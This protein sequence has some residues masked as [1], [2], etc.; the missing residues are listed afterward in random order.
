MSD[1]V[2]RGDSIAAALEREHQLVD[3]GIEA[4][5][6]DPSS[7]Q[8]SDRLAAAITALRRH[9]YLEEEFLFPAVYAADPAG[10]RASLAVMLREHGQMWRVLDEVEQIV[11]DDGDTPAA[12]SL[13]HRLAI[14]LQHHNRKEERVVYPLADTAIPPRRLAQFLES[15]RRPD[16]WVCIRLRP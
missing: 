15:G 4:F 6:A 7:P 12:L 11:R 2:E 8:A 9:I 13:C 14:Q 5:A 1:P 16:D 3:E 10:L